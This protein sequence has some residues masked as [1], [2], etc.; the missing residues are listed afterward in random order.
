MQERY[1]SAMMNL[2]AMKAVNEGAD[3]VFFLDADE[4]IN[5]DAK[6]KLQDYLRTFPHEVMH[7]PW[8]NL[9]PSKYG[10]F[11]MFDLEQE[12][13]WSGRVSPFRKV[14]LS[15]LYVNSNPNFVIHEGNHHVSAHLGAPAE[16]ER[17]GLTLLHMPVRSAD[18]L[19]YKL[20]NGVRLLRSKHNSSDGEGNHATKIL[21]FIADGRLTP[22]HLNVV[23]AN[24]GVNDDET[25]SLS[26]RDFDWPSKSFPGYAVKLKP[27]DNLARGLGETLMY[28]AAVKWE[29][30]GFV[31]GSAVAARICGSQI[32]IVAQPMTGG[33]TP[34]RGRYETLPTVRPDNPTEIGVKQLLESVST[35]FLRLKV[36]RFSAW[37]KLIPVL[38]A[39]FPL[40]RP[41]RYVELG[42]HN[43]MSFFAACQVAEHLNMKNLMRRRR[44]VGWRCSCELPLIRGV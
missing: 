39:M 44:F 13:S 40:L 20:A 3:W 34:F 22:E 21:R 7:L 29:K 11:D 26:P 4:F 2:L 16:T 31:K 36:M 18:R 38:F 25:E 37:S 6:I 14:A 19:K 33:G 43:G 17:L 9:V 1:Q 15:A 5:I 32:R 41:R 24:Y 42:V 28:D 30:P 10:R 27:I 35:S 8:I 23:A 12:F